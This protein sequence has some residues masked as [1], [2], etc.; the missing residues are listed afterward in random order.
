MLALNDRVKR[1]WYLVI[2][3]VTLRQS[4]KILHVVKRQHARVSFDW[5]RNADQSLTREGL[6][7]PNSITVKGLLVGLFFRMVGPVGLE[8]TTTPL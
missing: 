3:V 8:P 1:H 4:R 2:F 7:F 5:I 6:V